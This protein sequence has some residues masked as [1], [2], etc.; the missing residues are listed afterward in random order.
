MTND[1]ILK[2]AID[3]AIKNG[4]KEVSQFVSNTQNW[5]KAIRDGRFFMVIFSH[6]FAK[7]F[8]GEENVCY[9]CGKQEQVKDCECGEIRLIANY[10]L[11]LMVLV[12]EEDPIKYLEQFI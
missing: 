12:L 10:K 3:I 5:E 1:K 8:W 11:Q 2:L 6:D 4:F 7:A 9:K